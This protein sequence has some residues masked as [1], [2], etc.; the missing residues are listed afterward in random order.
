MRLYVHE[1]SLLFMAWIYLAT[2]RWCA[3]GYDMF[4]S[5][6]L[7][8]QYSPKTVQRDELNEIERVNIASTANQSGRC[9][10]WP[11]ITTM[12]STLHGTQ[13][14]E[15]ASVIIASRIASDN[16]A[17]VSDIFLVRVSHITQEINVMM[18]NKGEEASCRV[19]FT[20]KLHEHILLPRGLAGWLARRVYA[21]HGCMSRY[22]WCVGE[23][24]VVLRE[25]PPTYKIPFH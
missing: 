14:A 25:R 13:S 3:C 7:L 1:P 18:T 5:L 20:I 19:L 6:L 23:R 12:R 16:E 8:W 9:R 10:K 15:V 24:H 17:I 22:V 11:H 2:R 4:G 21:V